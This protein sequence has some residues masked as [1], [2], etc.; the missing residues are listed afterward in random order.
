MAAS[1]PRYGR[2]DS[3][4]IGHAGRS[5]TGP[6]AGHLRWS[7]WNFEP[8]QFLERRHQAAGPVRR[9]VVWL[10]TSRVCRHRP[11]DVPSWHRAWCSRSSVGAWRACAAS[12]SGFRQEGSGVIRVEAALAFIGGPAH[13]QV[14]AVSLTPGSVT[15]G[16]PNRR[17]VRPLWFGVCRFPDQS[18]PSR[19]RGHRPRIMVAG[20]RCAGGNEGRT[21]FCRARGGLRCW[22]APILHRLISHQACMVE[23]EWGYTATT[24]DM[25]IIVPV[26]G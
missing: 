20:Q 17:R 13:G 8:G 1:N 23:S 7:V 16:V 4:R 15:T 22:S 21:P 11:G 24:S 19:A 5:A 3:D 14:R 9:R 25:T 18:D 12:A 10:F 26:L 6:S 2:T